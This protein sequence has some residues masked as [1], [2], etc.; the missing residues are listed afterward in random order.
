MDGDSG[1]ATC[2]ELASCSEP[3]FWPAAADLRRF[4]P[5]T[6]KQHY[7]PEG[8]WGWVVIAVVVAVHVIGPGVHSAAGVF[9]AEVRRHF[10]SASALTAG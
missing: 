1:L 10:P 2:T 4:A 5:P 3:D 6:L 9:P 8:G 7:Y